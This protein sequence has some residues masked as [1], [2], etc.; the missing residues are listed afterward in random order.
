MTTL[1]DLILIILDNS[2]GWLDWS[3]EIL[4]SVMNGNSEIQKLGI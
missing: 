1:N 2:K 4:G 3:H